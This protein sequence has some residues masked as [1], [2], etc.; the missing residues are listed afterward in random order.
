MH[1]YAK[2]PDLRRKAHNAHPGAVVLLPVVLRL[3]LLGS[4]ARER[5][6]N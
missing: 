5:V 4:A 6:A 1:Q 3:P 2:Q